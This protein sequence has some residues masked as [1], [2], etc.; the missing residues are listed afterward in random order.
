[1]QREFGGGDDNDDDDDDNN[2]NV[3][4]FPLMIFL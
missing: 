1:L 2:N 3:H 4:S